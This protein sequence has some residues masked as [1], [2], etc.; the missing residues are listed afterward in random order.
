[1]P[2]NFKP[3]FR[4]NFKPTSGVSLIELLL[5]TAIFLVLAGTVTPIFG[6][7]QVSTQL[8][9]NTSQLIQVI[10]Q[11]R[12]QSVARLNNA[13]HGVFLEINPSD[14]DRFILYQG[15][16]YITRD[17]SYD[18]E[19]ILDDALVIST[20]LV[21]SEINFSKDLGSPNN[22]GTI[23]LTHSVTGTRTIDINRLGKVEVL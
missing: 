15:S 2:F 4:P 16:S 21:G 1:M 22:T 10:R 8:N 6:Q 19:Y 11:A 14:Q 17:S 13:A 12:N 9:E 3:D 20:T 5:A 18:L 7:L 23:S